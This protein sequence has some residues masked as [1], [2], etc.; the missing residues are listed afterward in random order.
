[1]MDDGEPVPVVYG[2]KVALPAGDDREFA[3]RRLTSG[4]RRH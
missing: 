4:S 2:L 1:M 3:A